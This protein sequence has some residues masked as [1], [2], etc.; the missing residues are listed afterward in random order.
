MPAI[1]LMYSHSEQTNSAFEIY[2]NPDRLL[3]KKLGLGQM[4]SLWHEAHAEAPSYH[5]NG[6]LGDM[7]A[8]IKVGTKH[9]P[10]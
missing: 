7:K 3:H 1:L 10:W 4:G 8:F 2:S 6:L 5:D 9:Q